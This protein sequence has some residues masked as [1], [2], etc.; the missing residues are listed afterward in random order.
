MNPPDS[1]LHS[2]CAKAHE[3]AQAGGMVIALLP[4]WTDAPWFRDF[5]QLS[6]ITFIRGKLSFVGR[7]GYSW[8]PSMV[9]LWTPKTVK[10]RP[11]TPLDAVLDKSFAVGGTYIAE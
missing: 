4:A 8:F 11:G 9:A 3:Y 5:V 6:R 1:D 7:K 2:W 10:R